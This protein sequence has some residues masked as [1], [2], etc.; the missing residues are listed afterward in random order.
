MFL[1][2]ISDLSADDKPQGIFFDISYDFIIQEL[3][4]LRKVQGKPNVFLL[5]NKK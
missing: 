3:I 1:K 4:Y 5:E 2:K